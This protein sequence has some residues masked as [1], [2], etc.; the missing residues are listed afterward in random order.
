[1]KVYKLVALHGGNMHCAS[2][3]LKKIQQ[4]KKILKDKQERE[5][6]KR[7]EAAG[8]TDGGGEYINTDDW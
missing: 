3:R 6:K 5:K 8:E 2:T 1:M 4:K 7:L